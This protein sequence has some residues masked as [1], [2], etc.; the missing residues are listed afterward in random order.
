M[1]T[2]RELEIQ[3]ERERERER[4]LTDRQKTNRRIDR[5]TNL[6]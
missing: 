1:Y 2:D 3:K 6:T 4:E 5:D